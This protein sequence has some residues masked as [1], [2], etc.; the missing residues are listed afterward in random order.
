MEGPGES[1]GSP[2]QSLPTIPEAFGDVPSL[3]YGLRPDVSTPG[4]RHH[5]LSG[6]DNHPAYALPGKQP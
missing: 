2:T 4:A 5:Q 6:P 3:S 1:S